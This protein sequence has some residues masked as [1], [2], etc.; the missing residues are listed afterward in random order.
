MLKERREKEMKSRRWST[1]K[2][3]ELERDQG[4]G[5]KGSFK[6]KKREKRERKN[7]R[8]RLPVE[9]EMKS[10]RKNLEREKGQTDERHGRVYRDDQ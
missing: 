8:S 9:R 1:C 3:V 5:K 2:K 6:R 10:T 4:R 7:L